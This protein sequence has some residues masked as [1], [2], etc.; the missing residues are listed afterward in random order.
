MEDAQ[1][2]ARLIC[3]MCREG[4]QLMIA[5]NILLIAAAS[6]RYFGVPP[7]RITGAS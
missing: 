1:P 6:G 4:R 3:I 2:P 7:A 5:R